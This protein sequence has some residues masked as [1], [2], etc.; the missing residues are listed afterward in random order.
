MPRPKL[1]LL[2]CGRTMDAIARDHGGFTD[3]F[4]TGLGETADLTPVNVR[5]DEPVPDLAAFDGLVLS[6][7]LSS[8]VAWESWMDA[9]TAAVELA[10]EGGMPVLGVC[11]GHQLLGK[12]LGGK[13]ALN[14]AGREMGTVHVEVTRAGRA[15]P[16]LGSLS[17]RFSAQ[18]THVDAVVEPPAGAV[19]LA[20]TELDGC[21]AMRVGKNVYGVQFHPE[22]SAPV[23]RR[24]VQ[25]R[26]GAIDGERVPGTARRILDR[27]R[28]TRSGRQVLRRWVEKVVEPY[29]ARHGGN[30]DARSPALQRGLYREQAAPAAD[31]TP[32]FYNRVGHGDP[33]VLMCAGIGCAQFAWKHMVPSLRRDHTVIRWHY[34]GHGKSPPPAGWPGARSPRLSIEGLADDAIRVMDHAGLERAVLFGH[35]MGVQ[36]V[37]EAWHRHPSRVQGMVLVCGSYGRPLTTFH[38]S[39]ALHVA[40]PFFY[41]LVRVIPSLSRKVWTGVLRHEV[42]YRFATTVEVNGRLVKRPDFKPYFDEISAV[43]AVLFTEVLSHAAEHSAEGFLRRINVPTLIVAGEHDTFTPQW[44]SRDMHV[45]I[46]GSEMLNVPTG[47][48][49]APIELPELV[50]LR[51][52]KWLA[53][54]FGAGPSLTPRHVANPS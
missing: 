27:V 14:P 10:M 28:E 45:S 47:T 34:P 48:H 3:W 44:L 9:V 2:L 43:D 52:E 8:V 30:G 18:A 4:A 7:S 38:D 1:L 13:V 50:E 12:V 17:P 39:A 20:Y 24:Y 11:F 32:I 5:D 21:A 25:A 26:A 40:F 22:I 46:P 37:L 6:G 54:H 41:R 53:R 33:A 35:S 29:A 49:T 42:A 23:M 15:D 36:V 19:V 51:L 31:G 16:V